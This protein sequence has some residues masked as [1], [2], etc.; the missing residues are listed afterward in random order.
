[1]KGFIEV[2]IETIFGGVRRRVI[3]VC[4][5]L[6]ITENSKGNA[7]I[8]TSSDSLCG[9]RCITTYDEVKRQLDEVHLCEE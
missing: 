6:C 8:Y 1:M 2:K 7:I 4:Q 5:I 3:P 9:L